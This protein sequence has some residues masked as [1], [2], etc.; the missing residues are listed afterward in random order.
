MDGWT[1]DGKAPTASVGLSCEDSDSDVKC[2]FD[3][4]ED[5]DSYICV[6]VLLASHTDLIKFPFP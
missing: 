5:G 2:E 3:G 6:S 4:P 1:F